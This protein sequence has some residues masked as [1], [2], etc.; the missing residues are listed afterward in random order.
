MRA[1]AQSIVETVRHPLVVLDAGLQVRTA[2]RSV[3][4]T[5]RVRPEQTEGPFVFTLGDGQ[6]DIALLRK[7]LLRAVAGGE[8]FESFELQ[9][10]FRISDG[11]P[12]C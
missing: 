11:R 10:D 4:E 9:Q 6:W 5:F 1:V 7:P 8:A 12:C 3:Y 2:N